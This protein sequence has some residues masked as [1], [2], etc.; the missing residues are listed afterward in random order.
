LNIYVILKSKTQVKPHVRI[1]G[2]HLS[3]IKQYPRE[4][5][6]RK[7]YEIELS[8]EG[9]RRATYKSDVIRDW[10]SSARRIYPYTTYLGDIAVRECIQNSLDAVLDA[11]DD[12]AIKKGNISI[13]VSED[14]MSYEVD[15]N[16]KGMSDKIIDE[17]LLMLHGASEGKSKEGRFG[18]LGMAK[19]VIFG[20]S[21][22]AH[23]E[24]WS[25]DNYFNGELASN[26]DFIKKSDYRQGTKIKVS[27]SN[28]IMGW[29][30]QQ[31]AETTEV[32]SSINIIY[33]GEKLKYP[34][35]NL[36]HETRT[37]ELNGNIY[38]ISY[39]PKP[40]QGYDSKMVIRIDDLKT[41]AKLSQ[42]INNI[43]SSNF[44]GAIVCDIVTKST[45]TDAAYPLTDSRMTLKSGDE[46]I[47]QLIEEKTLDPQ[48]AKRAGILY[49]VMM[50]SEIKSWTHTIEKIKTDK[51][52]NKLTDVIK[53]TFKQLGREE[54][55]KYTGLDHLTVKIDAGYKGPKGGNVMTAKVITAYEAIARLMA[56][57]LSAPLNKVYGMLSKDEDGGKVRAEYGG[58]ELGF[59]Y[60]NIDKRWFDSATSFAL[61]VINMVQHELTHSR[62]Y[63]HT[64]N[65]T[66]ALNS[67]Q[68]ETFK[69]FPACFKIATTAFG[70][71][72]TEL[73]SMFE[74]FQKLLEI[75]K[76][77]DVKEKKRSRILSENPEWRK[78]G[79]SEFGHQKDSQLDFI[80]K[81]LKEGI[82]VS[83]LV[84][85]MSDSFT[86]GNF[87]L[88]IKQHIKHLKKKHGITFNETFEKKWYERDYKINSADLVLPK[89]H[90]EN[91]DKIAEGGYDETRTKLYSAGFVEL[92]KGAK[93]S[94]GR[95]R[96]GF[97]KYAGSRFLPK[98]RSCSKQSSSQSL[99][100]S[101]RK[102]LGIK[103]DNGQRDFLNK[104][105]SFHVVCLN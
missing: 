61:G 71:E 73:L 29:T 11:L 43:G 40:P 18:G 4:I 77:T 72:P 14:R 13:S 33:N 75:S 69:L 105:K 97:S 50:T 15:D 45:P 17:N 83:D 41:G 82:S 7:S 87:R 49:K 16:G 64:E 47:R 96:R 21:E 62:Q 30:P 84:R 56:K 93:D 91:I 80:E 8:L 63:E 101:F 42:A 70:K 100:R 89:S 54:D 65:Y 59:N 23:W 67:V 5:P 76:K 78:K 38:T 55:A 86:G 20:P 19:A 34:F 58:G 95:S 60:A 25:R 12:G 6:G 102:S 103:R 9:K 39:Y 104:K 52:Y 48:S 98:S 2:G 53:E 99:K 51:G 31:Y 28:R 22:Y 46:F 88:T 37:H 26:N 1:R 3:F 32:P 79:G 10:N 94:K 24:L 27:S 57:D 36:R 68:M 85:K 44:R 35:K 66:T 92:S 81:R 90:L 74:A